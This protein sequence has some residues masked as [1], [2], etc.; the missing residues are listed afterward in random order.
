MFDTIGNHHDPD[1]GRRSVSSVLLTSLLATCSGTT[2]ALLG[3]L[4]ASDLTPPTL[5]EGDDKIFE[6]VD[7]P[8]ETYEDD[9]HAPSAPAPPPK[10]AAPAPEPEEETEDVAKPEPE[11]LDERIKELDRAIELP[12]ASEHRANGD[13]ADPDGDAEGSPD[14]VAGGI[15]GGVPNGTL[16]PPGGGRRVVHHQDIAW[17]R[18]H[19]DPQYPASA[20]GLGLGEQ[21]CLATLQF[22]ARGA[23]ERVQVDG[24]ARTFHES[25]QRALRLWTV[26]PPRV[27]KTKLPSQTRIKVRFVER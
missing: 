25:V 12:V 4:V 9:F 2:F 19:P 10:E 18:K 15:E 5:E 24:C 14:G 16:G 7:A 8:D 13:G 22:D 23:V 6:W 21:M 3:A 11:T 20:R 17:K 26:Y 1:A 27:G